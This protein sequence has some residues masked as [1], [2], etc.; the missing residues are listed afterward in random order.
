MVCDWDFPYQRLNGTHIFATEHPLGWLWRCAGGA[1]NDFRL[2]V[3][4]W[5]SNENLQ[6]ESIELRF[7]KWIGAFLFDGIL[8]RQYKEWVGQWVIH[9]SNR[10]LSLL[11]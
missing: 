11:H 8:S 4:G 6:H 7:W 9:T 3:R 10:Y 5:I 1:P 2:L